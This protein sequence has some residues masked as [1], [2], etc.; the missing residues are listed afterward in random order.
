MIT[1]ITAV[2]GSGKT[3]YVVSLIDKFNKEGRLVY[4]NIDGLDVD[5]YDHPN[6]IFD[7]PKD[8]R[9]TPD[10]SVVIYD[11]CQ[12]EDLYPADAKRGK[13][14]DERITAMET[15]R[16][17]GHDLIFITQAPTFVH[18]HIR[19]LVGEHIH[20]YR[21]ANMQRATKYVWPHTCEAPNDRKEQQRADVSNFQFP[22]EFFGYYKSAVL[23][24]H[25]F[26]LPAKV[27]LLMIVLLS[28]F[29]AIT[30]F[31]PNSEIFK[32]MFGGEEIEEI[33]TPTPIPTEEIVQEEPPKVEEEKPVVIYVTPT[34]MPI[35]SPVV[36]EAAFGCIVNTQRKL[37]SCY[38]DSGQ[39]FKQSYKKCLTM[40]NKP[41]P[42]TIKGGVK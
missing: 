19:K 21:V 34:P 13:V 10:G 5:K 20:F 39:V 7:A 27:K 16:H 30:Y 25:K 29:G 11:E 6:L 31:L 35:A 22:K 41:I 8:W 42:R 26:K 17:S 24:T 32:K 4:Q 23:H 37:C 18:H 36:E 3:L 38:D 12:Q 14:F 40:A 2:P 9:D 15:H 33:V 28:V 1:L